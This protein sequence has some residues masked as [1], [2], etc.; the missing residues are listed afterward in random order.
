VTPRAWFRYNECMRVKAFTI[1]AGIAAA[2]AC[3]P[4][5][6]TTTTGPILA[7]I[8]DGNAQSGEP[9]APLPTDVTITVSGA[10]GEPLAGVEVVWT[11]S[12]GGTFTPSVS[13]TNV[14]GRAS[15][16]WTLGP[17]RS[18]HV[19]R[20]VIRGLPSIEITAT[21]TG[22]PTLTE[23]TLL[24]IP[25][26]DGSGQAVHPD[27]A[28]AGESWPALRY[29]AITPYPNGN[30]YFENPSFYESLGYT[31]WRTPQGATNPVAVGRA[32]DYLSDPDIV[33]DPVERQFRLYYREVTSKNLI[34]MMRSPDG[35]Q[36]SRRT[37]VASGL[38]HVIVSPSVVRR[39]AGEWLMWSVNSNEGC[40]S[41]STTVELRRS[42]DGVTWSA[43]VTTDMRGPGLSAWHVDVQWI[44]ARNEYW[45][46]FNPKEAGS[47]TTRDLYFATSRDGVTWETFP[48]PVLS[49]GAIPEFE[50]IV[51]RSTFTYDASAGLITFWF[52]GARYE[53]HWIWRSAVQQRPITDLLAQISAAATTSKAVVPRRSVPPLTDPP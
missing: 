3:S 26:Y 9:G 48:T 36:W 10:Q 13:M 47:C 30:A 50:D 37:L 40:S 2:V 31:D 8:T 7:R 38:N 25:T 5:R 24:D 6:P 49:A 28:V 33:Y 45:A 20:A 12:D 23:L 11:A 32:P 1:V 21:S 15:A 14:D 22:Y 17:A 42:S 44:P 34:W 16:R 29:M 18:R 4:D 39:D 43:P 51:Y 41:T 35:S 46:L 19:A 53:G 27:V 52:S